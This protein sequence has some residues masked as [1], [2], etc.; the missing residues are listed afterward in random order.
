MHCK[1]KTLE[2]ILPPRPNP[3]PWKNCLPWNWCLMP[4]KLGTAAQEISLPSA[5]FWVGATQPVGL[6]MKNLER[7]SQP[8]VHGTHHFRQ[9]CRLTPSQGRA[10]EGQRLR[11]GMVRGSCSPEHLQQPKQGTDF[12][13]PERD[14]DASSTDTNQGHRTVYLELF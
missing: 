11:T 4:K 8:C 10:L 13:K 6:N 1:C 3:S 5:S 12:P 2:T 9:E 14:W 7:L